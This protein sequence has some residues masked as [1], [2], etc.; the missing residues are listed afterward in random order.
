M[1][2]PRCGCPSFLGKASEIGL[3]RAVGASKPQIF[4]QYL[5]ESAIVGLLGG[6]FGILLSWGGL[7]ALRA[8]YQGTATERL[9]HMDWAMVA[10]T[11]LI[12][13]A[14]SLMAGLYP[15][16]RACQIAPATQLK[17]Q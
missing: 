12:A 3:R 6:L 14:A 15:T 13:L 10:V 1:P 17:T 16:W 5:T 11:V 9:A 7:A 8:L 4:T 2:A